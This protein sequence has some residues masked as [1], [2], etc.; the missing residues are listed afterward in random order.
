MR[1]KEGKNKTNLH[2]GWMEEGE[3]LPGM[4]TSD[5]PREEQRPA[6]GKECHRCCSCPLHCLPGPPIQLCTHT[7]QAPAELYLLPQSRSHGAKFH[8]L[9][10]FA[11][12]GLFC[13]CAIF[14]TEVVI[15]PAP[16]LPGPLTHS[17]SP[18]LVRVFPGPAV[19]TNPKAALFPMS[20]P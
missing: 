19:S 17:C 6:W 9:S 18:S 16:P 5:K 14:S 4:G 3:L 11:E 1:G 7:A 12:R 13:L 8:Q 2:E 15:L 20:V 10:T